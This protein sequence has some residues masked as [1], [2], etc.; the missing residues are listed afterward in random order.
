MDNDTNG[1]ARLAIRIF[2]IIANSGATECN[3]SDF[4][5]IQ[6][7]KRS[8][9]SVD[10]THKINM[11]RMDIRRRHAALGVLQT[12]GKRKLGHDDNPAESTTEDLPSDN[13]DE[14]FGAI[15]HNLI[16][17][18]IDDRAADE[19]EDQYLS[20][21]A[22][23]PNS[24]QR[25]RRPIRTQLPL[26]TLFDFNRLDSGLDFYWTGAVKNLDAEADACENAF[27]QQVAD[28]QNASSMASSTPSSSV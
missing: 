10:K 20:S 23:V 9:L 16:I 28:M 18:A 5:N 4:G 25:S 24:T 19:A 27:S 1:I 8:R 13:E 3:F 11:V 2:S 17:A 15:A 7:K 14:N 12:R 22:L 6:T 21:P 26:A